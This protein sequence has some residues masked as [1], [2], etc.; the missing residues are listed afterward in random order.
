MATTTSSTIYGKQVKWSMVALSNAMIQS[1]DASLSY[2]TKMFKGVEGNDEAGVEYNAKAEFSINAVL[3]DSSD[4][5]AVKSAVRTWAE[6]EAVDQFGLQSGGSTLFT[7]FKI[8][9]NIEDAQTVDIS[10]TY[11]PYMQA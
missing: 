10:C 9:E 5:S 11:Y 6:Q 8:S 4:I 2:D 3:L 7:T 1:A